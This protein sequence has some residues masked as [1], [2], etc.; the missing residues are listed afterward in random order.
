MNNNFTIVTADNHLCISICGELDILTTRYFNDVLESI[1]DTADADIII[2]CEKL[3]YIDSWGINT[4][5]RALQRMK[6]KELGIR[7]VN[8]RK[9]VRKLFEITHLDYPFKIVS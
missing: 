3:I 8:L 5:V 2:D 4:L 9:D 7:L 6:Q 1:L